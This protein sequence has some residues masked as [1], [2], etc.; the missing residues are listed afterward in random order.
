[1]KI[2]LY[3]QRNN[4]GGGTFFSGLSDALRSIYYIGGL[5]TEVNTSDTP[6]LRSEILGSQPDD[7]NIWFWQCPAIDRAKGINIFWAIF[8]STRLPDWYLAYI[9]NHVNIVW[10]PSDWAYEVLIANGI[11]PEMIDIVPGGVDINCFQ[12]FLRKPYSAKSGTPFKFLTIGKYEE[13]KGYPQL[14]EGFKNAFGDSEDVQLLIKGDFHLK[15]ESKKEELTALIKSYGLRNVKTYWGDWTQ[16]LLI[17]LYN[18]ADSFVYPSRAEGWGL[19][20]IEAIAC[21]LPV[22]STFYSGHTEFL[23][24][25]KGKFIEIE[26][27]LENIND[28]EFQGYWENNN[29]DYGVWAKPN[30]ESITKNLLA[31]KSNYET[32]AEAALQASKIIRTQFTWVKAA[33]CALTS[34]Q[35]RGILRLQYEVQG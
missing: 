6:T 1:M 27:T 7:I 18:Y 2:R 21:G 12:P 29:T 22:T 11:S 25:I 30:S 10:A 8:E 14:L 20:L 31:L 24:P 33:E 9:K 3:G 4:L 17:G 19:P 23:K 5:I 16:D 34:I 28:V 32:H 26:S 15:H 35:S 13:R